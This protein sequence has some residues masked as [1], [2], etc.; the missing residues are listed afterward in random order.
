MSAIFVWRALRNLVMADFEENIEE[1]VG[2]AREAAAVATESGGDETATRPRT[3]PTVPGTRRRRRLV[4]R[5][6]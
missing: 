4:T 2:T 5:W 1:M 6:L 3:R